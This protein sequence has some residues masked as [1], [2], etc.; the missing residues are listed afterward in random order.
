MEYTGSEM[1]EK[2]VTDVDVSLAIIC[3]LDNGWAVRNIK[4]RAYF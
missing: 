1:Y 2:E 4:M 3:T